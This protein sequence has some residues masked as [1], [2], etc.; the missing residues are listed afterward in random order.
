MTTT[1]K[2]KGGAANAAKLIVKANEAALKGFPR[3]KLK[4]AFVAMAALATDSDKATEARQAAALDV[5]VLAAQF[6]GKNDKAHLDTVVTGWRDE[7]KTVAMELAVSGNRFAELKEGKGDQPATA[8][9]TGYGNNVA[10]IAKG[11]IEFSGDE[12]PVVLGESYREVRT[13]VEAKRADAR[14]ASDP[15]GAILADAK[16]AADDAW[17]ELRK[18]IFDTG[19]AGNINQLREVL[20]GQLSDVQAQL[21]AQADL[22]ELAKAVEELTPEEMA[23]LEAATAPEAEAI[24]A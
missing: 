15:D 20:E 13:A 4:A 9:L 16:Q 5:C 23:A 19:D 11:V 21:I 6:V 3:A 10:S 18:V 8:K 22:Q 17:T 24:A 12:E 7:F 1:K 14:R 2:D